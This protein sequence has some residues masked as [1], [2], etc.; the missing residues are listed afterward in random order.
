MSRSITVVF[1]RHA[2]TA[3]S[4]ERR[5]HADDAP[6]SPEGEAQTARWRLPPDL[7][8]LQAAGQL[9]W[10]TSP[11][12]RAVETG[13]RL[14][15]TVPVVDP[16]LAELDYGD[17]KGLR[18]E[19]VDALTRDTGWNGR[20][21]GGESPAEVLGRVRAWLDERAAQ[22]GPET[23]IAVTHGGVIRAVLGAAVGW[24][25]HPPSPWR[26][27]PERLHRIRRRANGLLQL[28]TLNEP[29]LSTGGES[30]PPDRRDASGLRPSGRPAPPV[31]PPWPLPPGGLST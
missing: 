11:L 2:A 17:W 3:W 9:G 23:W 10:A 18:F 20:P 8:R 12:R 5:V 22:P 28:V 13:R 14:G 29:L 30:R 26:P 31:V 16:R 1:L 24:D 15:A 19:E 7:L 27:L 4:A 25:L 21:P 6:L